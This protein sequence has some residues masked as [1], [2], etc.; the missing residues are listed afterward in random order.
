MNGDIKADICVIGA[1]SGGLSVAAAASMMGAKTV[2]IES[3]KMG[4]DCL[5]YGCVPSKALIAASK[6]AHS[7]RHAS[8]FGIRN[9]EPEVDFARVRDHVKGV[10]SEI[11]PNDSV[12]RF[13]GLG[14]E[15]ILDQ[16][17]FSGPREVIAGDRHIRARRF[18]IATGS[19]PSVPPIPGLA[20][21]PYLTN[22][23]IFDLENGP[24]HLIVIGGGA[25]GA[26]LAQAHRRLGANV[27]IIEMFKI[28]GRNDAEAANI[29]RTQLIADGITIH[30]YTVVKCVEQNGARISV[31]I[32]CAGKQL[33]IDGSH[34]LVA[35]GRRANLDG[36]NLETAGIQYSPKGIDVDVRLRTTNKKIFAIG[37]IA[38]PYQFTHMAGYHAGI[39]IRNALFKLPAKVNYDAVPWVIF[40]D[41]EVAHVGLTEDQSREKFGNDLRVLRW[42]FAEND[43]AQAERSIAGMI[44]VITSRRGRIRGASIVGL[45][46]GELIL[47]W[48]LAT[49]THG[50]ISKMANLI[51]PYPTLSDVTKRVAGTYFT[52]S[53]FSEHVKR[54]VRFLQYF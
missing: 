10:V 8:R 26:E 17:R 53:L 5:N 19:S 40:T 47:P 1:G 21:V 15:V 24:D 18:V 44:K 35:A 52:K 51:V 14:V 13:E 3:H 48:V 54:I 4:G 25:I 16:G 34:I 38:S 33:R 49:N 31:I 30:E 32:E 42:R 7:M 36:L 20:D 46:A 2:L 45:H 11:E 22:E 9:H 43:R 28:L 41:P 12:E 29:V 27:T 39:V 50:N 37:D 23:S 6:A